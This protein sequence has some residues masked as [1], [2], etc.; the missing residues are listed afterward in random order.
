V[1]IRRSGRRVSDE[2]QLALPLTKPFARLALA[3]ISL[4]VRGV[5]RIQGI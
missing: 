2:T 4:A 5:S 3:L 1:V